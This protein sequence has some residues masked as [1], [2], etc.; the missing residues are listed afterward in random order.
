MTNGARQSTPTVNVLLMLVEHLPKRHREL[1]D[2]LER[3][4][5]REQ[6]I[7]A[8]LSRLEKHA[9]VEGIIVGEP[10]AQPN[11]ATRQAE[12]AA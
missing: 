9:A 11:E 6:E 2:E 8:E 12:T 1:T 5:Q 10:D 7:R 4:N 3:V